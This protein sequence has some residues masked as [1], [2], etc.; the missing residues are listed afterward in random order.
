MFG[1]NS[2]SKFSSI[3]MARAHGGLARLADRRRWPLPRLGLSCTGDDRIN[4]SYGINVTSI[5]DSWTWVPDMSNYRF[6]LRTWKRAAAHPGGMNA[7]LADGSVRFI[8][9]TY[10]FRSCGHSTMAAAK[11]LRCRGGWTRT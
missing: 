3:P 4:L 1:D 6:R 8:S 7:C 2:D 10:R 11:P 5:P 9:E